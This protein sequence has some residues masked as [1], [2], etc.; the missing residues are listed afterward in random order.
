MNIASRGHVAAFRATPA[1]ATGPSRARV[2]VFAKRNEVSASYAK[3][4]VD[5]ASE[6]D[7]LDVVHAD[8]VT[9]AA[10]L[11]ENKA[12]AELLCNPVVEGGKK[13]AVLAKIGKD[14]GF[15]LYTMNFLNLL[16]EKDRMPLLEEICESFDEQYCKVTDTQVAVLRSAVQ[17]EQEQQFLI[18]K[19]LQELTGSKNIKLKPVIDKALIGGF[20]VEYG[21]S[22]IDLS[23][24]GQVDKVADELSRSLAVSLA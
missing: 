15:Q 9:V 24:R 1:R 7:K 4:L 10:L 2:T 6:K 20:V 18:A 16:V 8:V 21:S 13:R 5:L 22:Q 19:K 12:L 11:G 3:A 17:L 14:A 23:V